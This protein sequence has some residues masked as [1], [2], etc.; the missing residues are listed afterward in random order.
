[1]TDI[2]KLFDEFIAAHPQRAEEAVLH[3]RAEMANRHCMFGADLIPTFLKPIFLSQRQARDI[4]AVL[5]HIV[6]ILERVARLYFTHPDLREFFCITPPE[7]DLI[8]IDPGYAEHVL[9]SRPDSF[10]NNNG[11]RFVE[12]NCDSPAGAGYTDE[13]EDI[14]KTV[15]PFNELAESFEFLPHKR[16]EGLLQTLLHAYQQYAPRK[17]SP[18]IAIVDWQEVRTQNE[19]KIIQRYFCSQGCETVIA[20]PRELSYRQGRLEYKGFAIDLVYRRVIFRELMARVDDVQ[21]LLQAYRDQK[22]CVVNPLRSRLV[23]N[24]AIL[25]I[26]TNPKRFREFFDPEQNQIICKH[27]PWTR[28]VL[29]IETHFEDNRVFLRRHIQSHKDHLVLKPGDSYG[30]KDVVIGCETAQSEW[31]ALAERIIR[32]GEDW[33]VQRFVPIN[34][35]PVPIF[36]DGQ[37]RLQEKKYNIN[38]FIFA[39]IYRGSVARLSDQSVINVSAG[40]G[41]VPVMEYKAKDS[42]HE[43]H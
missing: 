21:A 27:I 31:D 42:D 30:G 13:E 17:T 15:F 1:M 11:L 25:A 8:A 39:G 37:V 20:D 29:D 5:H 23:S 3:L 38:P 43:D 36:D 12:F 7:H 19:F 26:M 14:L 35:T 32:D 18:H 40:G 24:K 34:R 16:L 4:H 2:D 41:L 6:Q 28:R 9:I 10:L 22:V 33:V